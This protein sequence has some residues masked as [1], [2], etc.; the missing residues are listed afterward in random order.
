MIGMAKKVLIADTIA[1]MI[2]PQLNSHTP[3]STGQA[4]LCMVGYAYQLYFDFSGY[5]DLAVGLGHL[6]F[7]ANPKLQFPL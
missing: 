7:E 4:W 5:S 3:L 6:R 2:N 1:L